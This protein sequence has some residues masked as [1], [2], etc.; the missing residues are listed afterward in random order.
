[1]SSQ[2]RGRQTKL[3]AWLKRATQPLTWATIAIVGA[4]IVAVLFGSL[5]LTPKAQVSVQAKTEQFSLTVSRG[6]RLP[7]GL[8]SAATHIGGQ[9]IE[10]CEAPYD[11]QWTRDALLNPIS[12]LLIIAPEGAMI[13]KSEAIKE[14]EELGVVQCANGVR[15]TLGT[16][17]LLT[18]DVKD[19]RLGE[20]VG[21]GNIEIGAVPRHTNEPSRILLSG[22]VEV[23]AT[24][25]PFRSG[26][27]VNERGLAKG[28]LVRFAANASGR[29]AAEAAFFLRVETGQFDVV[30]HARAHHVEVTRLGS[31]SS[32]S[33]N[34]APT[35]LDRLGAQG[36][37]VLIAGAAGLLASI[38]SALTNAQ[39]LG[40]IRD[41][42]K[43]GTGPRK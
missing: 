23:A 9:K 29:D 26:I 16:P 35:I 12:L 5:I 24:S 25:Y 13:I 34:S 36:E 41:I 38:F 18:L 1:M 43:R 39:A 21:R 30:A 3:G 32:F 7:E 6:T 17:F 10:N 20:L 33:V 31:S 4:A 40:E 14:K 15:H 37:L 2:R 42:L 8:P 22:R 28:D 19:W 11:V 27:L